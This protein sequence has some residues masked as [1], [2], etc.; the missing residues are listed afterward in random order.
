MGVNAATMTSLGMIFS[1]DLN[2]LLNL[3]G[4]DLLIAEQE[5]CQ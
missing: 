1:F 4:L 3:H 5:P 2:V